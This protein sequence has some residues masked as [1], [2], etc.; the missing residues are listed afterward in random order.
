MTDY[1]QS[2]GIT[3]NAIGAGQHVPVIENKIRQVK[4]HVRAIINTLSFNL[5]AT[6]LKRLIA[7]AVSSLTMSRQY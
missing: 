5:P 7:H 2:I 1:L 3:V 4:E 6:M